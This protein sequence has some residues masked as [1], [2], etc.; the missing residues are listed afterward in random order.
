[1]REWSKYKLIPYGIDPDPER[2]E[3]VA[4]ILPEFANNFAPLGITQLGKLASYNLPSQFDLVYWNVWDNFDPLVHK[5]YIEQAFNVVKPNG[6][7]ILGFYCADTLENDKKIA[8][9]KK[10]YST[11][12]GHK[13][14]SP[15]TQSII[16]YDL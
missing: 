1:M 12:K 8:W 10:Y 3:G 5:G 6:R 2:L 14:T 4:E 7:L 9:F 13:D 15:E 16:W 11:P